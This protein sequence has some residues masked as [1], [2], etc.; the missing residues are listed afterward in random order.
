MVLYLLPSNP[1]PELVQKL[2]RLLHKEPF[3]S[4]AYAF[5]WAFLLCAI[6]PL[7][8]FA[9]LLHLLYEGG[10]WAVDEYKKTNESKNAD[11]PSDREVNDM[12][13][14]SLSV[15]IT[16]CDS[17]FGLGLALALAERGYQVFAGCLNLEESKS[18]FS[19][20]SN[21][22]PL[23]LDV[24]KMDEIETSVRAVEYWLSWSPGSASRQLYALVNNAGMGKM[25]Q[26]DWMNMA[27][28]E[29]CMSGK[30]LI[31]GVAFYGCS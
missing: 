22:T 23:Q 8:G 25:A 30:L 6:V 10:R 17:G 15:V 19:K 26:V 31:W 29:I 14:S 12:D 21:V 28:F 11:A 7:G 16:G 20:Y 1:P 9:L 5:V 4:I 18:L 13:R 3:A 24:T 27:D 2:N